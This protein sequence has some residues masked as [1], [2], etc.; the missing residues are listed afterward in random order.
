[1]RILLLTTVIIGCLL[2]GLTFADQDVS[3]LSDA[4]EAAP[5][6][7]TIGQSVGV[8]YTV[9]DTNGSGL[10]HVELWRKDGDDD[11]K[12]ISRNS[13]AGETGEV[14]GS[15]T[16]SP[17]A[18]GK[19]W[20]GVHVVDNAGNE[21]DEQNENTANQPGDWGPVEVAVIENASPVV[22]AFQVIPLTMNLGQS[23]EITYS[24]AASN[25]SGSALQHV[26]LWRKDGDNDWKEISRNSIEGETGEV[27]GSFTDSPP[28]AG[29]FWYGVHVVDN[30]GN[31]NDEQNEN[32]ANQPGDWG[33]A[34][35]A[36]IENA[37]PVVL[38]FQ[39]APLS[40]NLG[41]SVEITYSVAA[42]NRS[43]SGLQQ[44]E[45]WR[46]DGDEDWQNISQKSLVGET[47]EVSGSFTDSPPGPG[48]FWY[49]VH[50]VDNAGNE[51]DEQNENTANRP[52]DWGPAE[53]AVIEPASPVVQ[54]FQVAPL[55]S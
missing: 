27:S 45:L 29:K 17:P 37:S 44:V 14:S 30:A 20:Y 53:V 42:S 39:V 38:A 3:D 16:D 2:V 49:G 24:V 51:N 50:V 15:F 10:Q 40:L 6:I 47:G 55:T 54:A 36:V 19:F 13:L 35:V 1:M 12:E 33:P 25:S 7:V 28:A 18:A 21:N 9:L 31:E 4:F 46:K 26:E 8:N 11:W 41:E 52:G 22:Q 34:K 32:T 23:V 48:K 5:I 43:G